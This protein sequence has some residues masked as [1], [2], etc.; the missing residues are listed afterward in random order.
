M[1]FLETYRKDIQQAL[2]QFFDEKVPHLFPINRWGKDVVER[3]KE[4]SLSGK[5]IRGALILFAEE[6]FSGQYTPNAIKAAVSMELFQSGLLIHDDI[7][8][9]DTKRR[10]KTTIFY[11]YAEL[12]KNLTSSEKT[13]YH[14][15]ESMG[16]C[17]GDIA[18]FLGFENL[19]G[20]EVSPSTQNKIY[21]TFA[22]EMSF[23][24]LGQMQD[25]FFSIT[26]EGLSENAILSI[27]LYKTSRYTFSLPLMTGGIL[28]GVKKHTLACLET[29]GENLGIIF[30][31]KDDEL[32]LFGDER[33][34]GKPVGSD[35][36]ENKKTLY[37]WY[38]QRYSSEEEKQKL[39]RIFGKPEIT[40]EDVGYVHN[41]ITKYDIQNNIRQKQAGLAQLVKDEIASLPV[42]ENY[43]KA[44]L[45]L[46]EY[47]LTRNF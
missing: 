26:D 20:L 9:Q 5:M 30:Q 6:M 13:A 46:L 34:T 43:Q 14:F 18:F 32:G 23:V 2:S 8:D 28:A 29:I 25:V 19:S 38:L 10:G 17:V 22:R 45:E 27:Y 42:E 12:A 4:F 35:I 21:Q 44:L 7:M 33:V 47:N 36:Q 15:G 16:I 31:I 3:L 1:K 40:S 39:S 41:L 24:G 37:F 11:Q